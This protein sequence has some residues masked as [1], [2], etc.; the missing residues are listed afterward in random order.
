MAVISPA[1]LL[2]NQTH[3]PNL[4]CTQPEFTADAKNIASLLKKMSAIELAKLMQMSIALGKET[5]LTYKQWTQ[6]FTHDNAHPALLMFKGEVYRGLQAQELHLKQLQFA[7]EHVRILSGLY[8]ILRPLDLVMPYRLMMGTKLVISKEHKNLYHYWTTKI[9]AHLNESLDKKGILIDLASSEYFKSID[10][11]TLNRKVVTCEFRQKKGNDF[12]VVNTYAKSARGKM[13]R[14][15]I[16]NTITKASD[17]RAFDYDGYRLLDARSD[18][19]R[20]VFAR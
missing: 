13:A 15:I 4:P 5:E 9:T 19:E 18:A 12:V 6:P 11:K 2:D 1:K 16:D 14:F 10:L 8:G 20:L 3:Y 7:Q 17:C